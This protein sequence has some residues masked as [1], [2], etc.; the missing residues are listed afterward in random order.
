MVPSRSVRIATSPRWV[1]VDDRLGEVRDVVEKLVVYVF[2]NA[3]R[4]GN[5]QRPVH[6]QPHLG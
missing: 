2:R 3:V 6:A 4:L 1:D 5:W